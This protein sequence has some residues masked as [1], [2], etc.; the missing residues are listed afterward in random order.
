MNLILYSVT[1]ND[2]M[3]PKNLNPVASLVGSVRGSVSVETPEILIELNNFLEF[4]YL[5]CDEFKRYYYV[6]NQIAER[7]GVLRLVCEVD[8]LQSFYSQFKNCPMIARRS[9]SDYNAYIKD[10]NR[11]FMQYTVQQ[12][13]TLG[14]LSRPDTFILVASGIYES[15]FE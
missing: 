6:R 1:D 5:Y 3:I 13:K 4:N 10:D 12:Y 8:V 11:K 15:S 2:H 7:T 9:D 14:H